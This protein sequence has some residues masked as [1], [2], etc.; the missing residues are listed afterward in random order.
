MLHEKKREHYIDIQK[1]RIE[2]YFAENVS[3]YHKIEITKTEQNPITIYL[4][5][6]YI[7]DDKKLYFTATMDGSSNYQFDNQIGISEKLSNM[8]KSQ[9]KPDKFPSQIIK[10]KNLNEN[11]YKADPPIIFSF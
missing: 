8:F 7:N 4:I 6:G 11:D 5:K 3:S 2:M 1:K 9:S 10:E